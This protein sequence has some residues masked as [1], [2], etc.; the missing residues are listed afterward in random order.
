MPLMKAPMRAIKKFPNEPPMT[1][2]TE[3]IDTAR[4][5]P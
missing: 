3:A 4:V 2:D 1:E 5:A